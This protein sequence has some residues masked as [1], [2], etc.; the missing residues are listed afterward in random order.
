MWIDEIKQLMSV[1]RYR[2]E[3]WNIFQFLKH[4]PQLGRDTRM[5]IVI[6]DESL[7]FQN[8]YITFDHKGSYVVTHKYTFTTFLHD[9][10]S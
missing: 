2:S 1:Q 10:S 6:K 8:N 4:K 9:A 3:L 7:I 5:L